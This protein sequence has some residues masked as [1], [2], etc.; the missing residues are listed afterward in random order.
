[1]NISRFSDLTQL[2]PHT[3][4]Y[5]EKIGL[6]SNISRNSSGHRIYTTADVEW[7][8]FINRLKA[9]GMPLEQILEY[10]NLRALGEE[11]FEQR[12]L[13]LQKHRD[14]LKHR[15]ESE[16]EHLQALDAKIHYYDENKS[17]T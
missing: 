9:T 13:L 17:L 3:L 2:S 1:M 16:L 10:S 11:T 12:R 5:Y 8:K 4:R 14:A 15:I 6:L 7:A